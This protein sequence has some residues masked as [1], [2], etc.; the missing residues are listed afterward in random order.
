MFILKPVL[1]TYGC[2]A[3][4]CRFH[5]NGKREGRAIPNACQPVIPCGGD[6]TDQHVKVQSLPFRYIVEFPR[7][8]GDRNETRV[9]V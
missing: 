8:R 6:Q 7:I 5:G 9:I 3:M 4:G 2:G 1:K